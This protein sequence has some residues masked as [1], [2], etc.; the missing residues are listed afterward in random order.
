MVVDKLFFGRE[1]VSAFSVF[2]FMYSCS[3]TTKI[4]AVLS[5]KHYKNIDN[6]LIPIFFFFLPR[7][8]ASIRDIHLKCSIKLI[9]FSRGSSV[10]LPA[11]CF[12]FTISLRL[13]FFL[14]AYNANTTSAC[15]NTTIKLIV[16][17]VSKL[18]KRKMHNL[19]YYTLLFRIIWWF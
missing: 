6:L 9:S 19:S 18:K 13:M 14:D 10:S 3:T 5:I 15:F 17:E 1:E 8:K 7:M 4:L 16:T 11:F 12:F 2:T